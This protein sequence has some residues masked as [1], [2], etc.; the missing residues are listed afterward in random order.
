[1]MLGFVSQWGHAVTAI[2]F[3]AIA[4]WLLKDLSKG[5]GVWPLVLASA[6][7]SAWAL[8]SA[9]QGAAAPLALAS[10]IARNLAWLGFMYAF[11]R[12]DEGQGKHLTVG[13]LYGALLFVGVVQLGF[14]LVQADAQQGTG[15]TRAVTYSSFVLGMLFSVGALVLV[16]NLYTAGTTDTRSAL[17]LPLTALSVIWVYDLNLYTVSYLSASWSVELLALRGLA[18]GMA[19]PLIALS[20]NA[21]GGL[22]VRLSRTATFQTLSLG[23]IGAYL[24]AM[25][26][27]NAVLG[28]LLGNHAR[29]VQVA[30]VFGCSVIALVLL[31][32]ARFRAWF[33]VKIAKHL[34]Q[35]R[36]DYRAEWL[37]FSE[38]LG[39]PGA[40]S[41]PLDTRVVQALADITESPFGCLMEPD[42]AG[43]LVVR[44]K[45]NWPD[46]ASAGQAATSRTV[47]FFERTGR[48]VELD[49]LRGD[50]EGNDEE[51]AAVP[52]WL[53]ADQSAWAIV[54]LIHFGR[55][56]GLVVLG[57]P[58]VARTLD[59]ED[60]DLLKVVGSQVAT[61][62]AEAHGQEA[63][64]TA[65]RFD[66]FNRRFA[67]I[68]HDIKNLVS[69]L[70]LVARNAEKYAGNPD[71][72][73]DMIVT[74]KS[75]VARMND[76]LARLSQHNKAQAEEPR[77][78]QV[79]PVLERI[80]TAKRMQHAVVTTGEPKLYLV[81]DP[82][83]LEQA[84][85]HLVQNA[86]E[87]SP[88][89][90]PVTLRVRTVRDQAVIEVID[91]G[92]GM[93][94]HFIRTDLFKPFTSTKDGG[95]GVG[96][97]EARALVTAMGGRLDVQSREGEGTTFSIFLPLARDS[98]NMSTEDKVKAA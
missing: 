19:A 67:F 24:I 91:K 34:F 2:L 73:A 16:H 96:A 69:Q 76:L 79:G 18:V 61:Y 43:S 15:I 5:R 46:L 23:A 4:V 80:V 98:A 62:L 94:T 78:I 27:L 58:L 35:H 32:S 88:P 84:V 49:A 31:P 86:I 92:C 71:F 45:W 17:R 39:N 54:P 44:S 9:S 93:S 26:A 21:A 14:V 51:A 82:A 53:L 41:T 87:A 6:M 47:D 22:R 13:A 72:Q 38:T 63:L 12:R 57:R 10:E 66:E 20:A 97:F 11:W 64:A 74:L 81:A 65:Q 48:I 75:S 55:L 3:A 29:P 52:E 50:F 95:F 68:M 60:F 89:T 36:Y 1:M 85:V 42:G 70:S 59:W 30:F 83:R 77:A 25:V 28:A 90:E 8:L 37:R 56:A 40:T 7:T 33:K